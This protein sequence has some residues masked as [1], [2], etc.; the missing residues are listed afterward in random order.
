MRNQWNIGMHGATGLRLEALPTALR[1]QG[2]PRVQWAEVA[3]Q[4]SVMESETL[5]LWRD[6]R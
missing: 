1:L 3:E 2:V 6:K 5:R 4:V